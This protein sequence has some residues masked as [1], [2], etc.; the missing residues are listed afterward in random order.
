L[1]DFSNDVNVVFRAGKE[2]KIYKDMKIKMLV[3]SALAVT[4]LL[5]SV[6]KVAMAKQDGLKPGWGWGPDKTGQGHT[7]PQG[8]G[9]PSTHP[10]WGNNTP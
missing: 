2:V 3:I 7:G 10:V 9:A 1:T 6:G 4:A 5:L 8:P